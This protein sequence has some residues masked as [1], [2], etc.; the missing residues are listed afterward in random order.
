MDPS[1]SAF[2]LLVNASYNAWTLQHS[3]HTVLFTIR[4]WCAPRHQKRGYPDEQYNKDGHCEAY[5]G[6]GKAPHTP[7]DALVEQERK[8]DQGQPGKAHRQSHLIRREVQATLDHNTQ[9][10]SNIR[11]G[12]HRVKTCNR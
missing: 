1:K 11:N 3:R 2:L 6:A 5:L 12:I 4:S 10:T 9:Q 7:L 8:D